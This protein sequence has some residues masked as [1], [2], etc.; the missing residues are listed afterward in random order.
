MKNRLLKLDRIYKQIITLSFDVIILNLSIWLAFFLQPDGIFQRSMFNN[1][2]LFIAI[3][4]IAIPLFIKTGLYRSVLQYTGSKV[5]IATLQCITITS[6]VATFIHY[7][8]RVYLFDL[9]HV[10]PR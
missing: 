1:W 7:Y 6:I 10:L 5:I 2:W 4:L 9:N 3:P 8:G